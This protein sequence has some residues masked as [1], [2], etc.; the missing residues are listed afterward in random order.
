MSK[1]ETNQVD[2]ATGT[3]LTLGTSGDTVNLG[4]GVTAGNFGKIAQV[5]QT[6]KTDAW[7]QSTTDQTFYNPTGFEVAIT[8]SSTSSKIIIMAT[9]SWSATT[10]YEIG[11]KIQRTIGATTT[12]VLVAD[13][14][15]SRTRAFMSER[16]NAQADYG[17]MTMIVMDS[18]NTTSECTYKPVAA[19][20]SSAT[21]YLNRQHSDSNA[22][23]DFRAASSIIVA[24]ILA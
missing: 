18:P 6:T 19:T 7:S 10:N 9:C 16:S 11:A 24:E 15:G 3:T 2:P 23:T 22:A 13:A 8:P 17:S 12:D 4:S 14:D 20:E 5:I 21:L 1:L